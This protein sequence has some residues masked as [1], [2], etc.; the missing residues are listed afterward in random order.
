MQKN[1]CGIVF[2]MT[3]GAGTDSEG[4]AIASDYVVRRAEP[5]VVG[6]PIEGGCAADAIANPDNITFVDDWGML[7]IAEDTSKHLHDT[8]WAIDLR[9]GGPLV[10]LMQVD[11]ASEVT[12]MHWLGD[13]DG[14]GY[15]TVSNQWGER[16][17]PDH[18]SVMGV[19]GPFP[20]P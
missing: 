2:S 19:L 12:G 16:D 3:M 11:R 10:P 17:W 1:A 7:L 6:Q 5:A 13:I 9:N 20:A 15:L 4:A 8:L 14:H 18:R